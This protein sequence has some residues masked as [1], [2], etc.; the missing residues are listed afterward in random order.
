M[1]LRSP[2]TKRETTLDFDL[3]VFPLQN[4]GY[5]LLFWKFR[6]IGSANI[7]PDPAVTECAEIHRN[8]EN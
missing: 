1:A 5:N 6:K 2:L 8:A 7:N 4:T 3:V